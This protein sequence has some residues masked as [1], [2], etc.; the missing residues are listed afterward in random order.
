MTASTAQR[1]RR[2]L[3]LLAVAAV[4]YLT[5]AEVVLP[6][7]DQLRTAPAQAAEKTELLRKYKRELSHQGSY[8][9]LRADTRNKLSE[10]RGFFF[11]NDAAGATELQKV[12][13]ESAKEIGID[14]A[15]RTATQIRKVDDAVS[16]ITMAMSFECTLNQLVS[17]L[18]QLRNSPKL[19]NVKIAQI[20]PAQVVYEAPKTGELKKSVRVNLTVAGEAVAPGVPAEGKVK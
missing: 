8:D 1:N 9:A 20:D 10:A 16:E 19:V 14:L 15:Q 13:E 17:F 3:I 5:S 4:I 6:W 2:A 7:Y 11:T 12:V 18:D